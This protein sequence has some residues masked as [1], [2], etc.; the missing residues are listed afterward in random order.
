M[1]KRVHHINFVVYELDAAVKK[2]QTLFGLNNCEFLDHPHRRV[3]TARFKV[4]ESWI[5][6]LQPLDNESPPGKHLQQH[7]EGFFLISYEV[8]DLSAAMISIE[9]NGGA[10]Q[11]EQAREG[12]LNWQVADL[13]PE[14]TF[15][16]RIQLVE[17]KK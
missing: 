2:Y 4:G 14:S 8:E 12:I 11:D 6:L 15:G 10:V 13:A 3:L 17:E 16:T 9:S 5:V 7:G 1:L